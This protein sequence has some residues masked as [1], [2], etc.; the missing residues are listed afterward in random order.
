MLATL[1]SVARDLGRRTALGATV[2][3]VAMTLTLSSASVGLTGLTAGTAQ[4]QAPTWTVP[5]SGIADGAGHLRA[6][7]GQ[8]G[9]LV[10]C[11]QVEARVR[12][13][14]GAQMSG[15]GVIAI[16]SMTF[17]D[18]PCSGV[19]GDTITLTV[20]T[21][22]LRFNALAY[23]ASTS[24]VAGRVTGITV[25]ATSNQGCVLTVAGP[26]GTA[27]QVDA[28]Y[29]NPTGTITVKDNSHLRVTSV[30]TGCARG[31]VKVGDN[32]LL[33]GQFALSPR[34]IITSP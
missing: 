34:G 7:H 2:V 16:T 17:G 23:D 22:P 20:A 13:Q 18:A 19:L 12:A 8:M 11:D 26:N 24:V 9:W 15:D 6:Q 10:I 1:P 5:M 14:R 30:T 4:A 27:G 28:T 21:L 25:T 3:G 33:E 31:G 32:I 29:S